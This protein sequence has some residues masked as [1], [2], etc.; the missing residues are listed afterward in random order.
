MIARIIFPGFRL[1]QWCP[2]RNNTYLSCS[3]GQGECGQKPDQSWREFIV[4]I[5]IFTAAGNIGANKGDDGAGFAP[6]MQSI[7]RRDRRKERL[8]APT[9]AKGGGTFALEPANRAGLF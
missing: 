6:T 8:A 7:A 9:G 1:N 3:V 4:R 5:Q 2:L